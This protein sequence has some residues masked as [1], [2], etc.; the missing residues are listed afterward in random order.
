M[1]FGVA[2]RFLAGIAGM[3]PLKP[4]SRFKR[5]AAGS[6]EQKCRKVV[7]FIVDGGPVQRRPG[8]YSLVTQP[9]PEFE[10]QTIH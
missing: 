2:R 5:I 1:W 4:V 7:P 3:S 8:A 10:V 6:K 9:P